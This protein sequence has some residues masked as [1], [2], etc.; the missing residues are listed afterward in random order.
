[1]PSPTPSQLQAISAHGNVLVMAGAGTGKTR[2]LV[3]RC[4]AQLL[5]VVA[6]CDLDEILIVTFTE[7]AAAEMKR[8]LRNRIEE[9]IARGPD[10]QRLGEQLALVDTAPIGTLHS[11]CL[12]LIRDHFHQLG[13]DPQLSVLEES[14]AATLAAETL[15]GVLGEHYRGQTE[16]DEAVRDLIL[17]YGEGRDEPV[18]QLVERVYGYAQTLPNPV[19]WI[20]GLERLFRGDRPSEWESWLHAGF[21][22]MRE[23]WQPI[24]AAVDHP[25]LRDCAAVL[26]ACP[27]PAS[28]TNIATAC[29]AIRSADDDANWKRVKGKTAFRRPNEQFFNDAEFLGSLAEKEGGADPLDEDW[30]R[31]RPHM[32]TLVSLVREFGHSY[33]QAKRDFAVVDFHDLEQFALRLLW[34]AT[35]N[36][37]TAL[38]QRYADRFRHVLVDE[39]QDINAAQ[40]CLLRALSRLEPGNRFLVGDVKQSIY[41][42]RL[43]NPR[44]FQR[45]ASQ[46]RGGIAGQTVALRGNF[47]SHEAIL[48]FVNALFGGCLRPEMGGVAYDDAARLDFGG[49]AERQFFARIGQDSAESRVELL[50]RLKSNEPAETQAESEEVTVPATNDTEQEA[51]IIARHL[52]ELKSRPLLVWDEGAHSPR[53]VVWRDMVVLL[54]A[55]RNRAE[56][57]A[58][59]FQQAGIPLVSTRGGFYGATE[60][61]DL[62]NLLTL[63]DNPLQ[64]LPVLAVLR[65]PLV[66]LTLDELT[67]VR[68]AQRHASLWLALLKFSREGSP[69]QVGVVKVTRFLERFARWRELARRGALSVCLETILDETHYEDWLVAQERGEQ[70]RANVHRLLTL[71]RQFDL[72]QHQGLHRFLRFV[73]A[74]QEVEFDPEPATLDTGDAVRLMSIHQSKGLEF[75]VV[76]VA[77]L[78]VGF[79]RTDLHATVILDEELGLAPLLKVPSHPRFYPS[80]PHWL[81]RRWQ[82]HELLGEEG[83]LL[84][85]ATTR[86]AERLVLVG[87]VTRRQ[88]GRAHV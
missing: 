31:L 48:D 10:G 17:V 74:Q 65:S 52:A 80:L 72:L 5:D 86:A 50:L 45:Y 62:L 24:L 66:A 11:I 44:I 71:T 68:I 32:A 51:W 30:S 49:R 23:E 64:D 33:A 55:P 2:T 46:W 87:T 29:A 57:F 42:F 27:R 53:P 20:E 21:E 76:V 77:G 25:I 16:L 15:V 19:G 69:A 40:D 38:A 59:V 35:T 54:R 81:A 28:R 39:Y 79:N 13:L 6:P 41:R 8:R 9:E 3:E 12:R 60:V 47:R 56:A 78:G 61:T 88:I 67:A 63:L 1:M 43:A 34:D 58:Q 75:P 22:A 14:R 83:R 73:A 37:P 82:W 4:L 36:R 70:R 7:A 85:V 26:A 84:Y 18:R